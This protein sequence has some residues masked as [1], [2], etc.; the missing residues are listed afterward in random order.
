VLLWYL[1][2]GSGI[3]A[4]LTGILLAAIIP[5]RP[6]RSPAE[7]ERRIQELQDAFRADRRDLSTPDDP[8]SNSRMASIAEAM[9][10]C[11]IAVQSPLHRIEHRLTPWVTFAI[12]PLFAL[13]NAGIDLTHIEWGDALASRIT[14]GVLAGLVVGKL[15]GI[16]VFS[17][18]AVRLGVARLPAGVEWR[19]LMGAGW[20]A[21]IGFT[22]SL[23]IGQLAFQDP[24]MIADAKLGTLL[25]SALSAT[26]GLTWLFWST[27]RAQPMTDENKPV[28][29]A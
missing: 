12:L 13:A 16:L 18:C 5:V 26:I 25:A 8:L 11:A 23:F 28:R 7:F 14:L 29:P 20:L 21:G 17:W 1:L 24:Q 6:A 19:H 9:K 2:H 22:M 4:T 10:Y 27:P 3:H 15:L